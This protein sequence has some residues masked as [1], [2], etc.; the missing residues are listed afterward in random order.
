MNASL[1][2]PQISRPN[3]VQMPIPVAAHSL[4]RGSAAAHLL[5]LRFRI[6]PGAWLSVCCECCVLSGKGLC[7]GLITR[8][9]ESDKVWCVVVCN[10]EALAHQGL[11]HREKKKSANGWRSE[12]THYPG[13]L[14]SP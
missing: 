12:S 8:A 1:N 13:V 4:R 7:V 3:Q 14:I 11:L 9:E 2:K 5:R 6:P 10:C